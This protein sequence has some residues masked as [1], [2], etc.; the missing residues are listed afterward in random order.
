MKTDVV[1]VE[2][3][4]AIKRAVEVLASGG[5]VAFPT[6]TV[7]GLAASP[8]NADAVR[9]LYAVKERPHDLPIPLLLSDQDELA[10][11]AIFPD[12]CRGLPAQ[13]W[14]GGLTLVV[15]KST[16]VSRAVTDRPTVA[17][18]V[19]DHSIARDLIRKAGGVLAVTSANRSGEP[20]PLTAQQVATQ[21]QGR[22][23]LIL[24]GGRCRVGVASTI[25]D[26]AAS[27]P[28]LLRLG[29]VSEAALRAV[30]GELAPG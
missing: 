12:R 8:W 24:D 9:R 7:Y 26:C 11:V 14:P 22:I 16:A 15:P 13:F 17:V 25:V 23:P 2:S 10:R 21:L 5:L 20:S 28:R 29:A 27:P 30:V 3:R 4:G 18:R 1:E 6:D 19:P